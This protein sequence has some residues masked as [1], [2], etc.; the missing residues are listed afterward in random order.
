MLFRSDAFW[1]SDRTE[2]NSSR[3]LESQ[4]QKVKILEYFREN[5]PS[6]TEE[7]AARAWGALVAEQ[8]DKAKQDSD[9]VSAASPD[10]PWALA[11]RA[12]ALL[13]GNCLKEKDSKEVKLS[14]ETLKK[15]NKL[16]PEYANAYRQLAAE[17]ECT[18][19]TQEAISSHTEAI[20]YWP[21]SENYMRRGNFYLEIEEKDKKKLKENVE[22]AHQ[23]FSAALE[24]DPSYS[25]ANVGLARVFSLNEDYQNCI[26]EIDKALARKQ[27]FDAYYW[28]SSCR[29]SLAAKEKDEKGFDEAITNLESSKEQID[30]YNSSADQQMLLAQYYFLKASVYNNK[31]FYF[32]SEK[33]LKNKSS[34]LKTKIKAELASA[35][36]SVAEAKSINQN[37][38]LDKQIIELE[39]T[40]KSNSKTLARV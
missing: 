33:Y 21:S 29:N 38:V 25:E 3:N 14:I 10:W 26:S 8:W 40:I 23:D 13:G 15:V 31:A 27:F 37:K 12:T 20:K 7:Y 32:F 24:K 34:S 39:K 16:K 9:K 6:T 18:G 36:S 4:G 22:K 1:D 17:Y 35:Q 30:K 2:N 11:L 19:N 28:R 5:E